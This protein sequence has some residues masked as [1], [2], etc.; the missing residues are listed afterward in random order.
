[1]GRIQGSAGVR[2]PRTAGN[3]TRLS[4]AG[5]A[6]GD[7]AVQLLDMTG[8]GSE[9]GRRL[10]SLRKVYEKVCPICG[11]RFEGIARR[12]YDRAACQVKAYR[13]RKKG[14]SVRSGEDD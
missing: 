2:A 12:V 5:N 13:V 9:A 8:E 4:A 14:V 3:V 6:A 10:S 11:T 7:F 1:V